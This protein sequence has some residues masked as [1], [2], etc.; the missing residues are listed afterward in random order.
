MNIPKLQIHTTNAKLG[1]NIHD[2][3][4][5]IEQ[6]PADLEIKQPP[7][8]ITIDVQKGELF[9][10]ASEARSYYGFKTVQELEKIAAQKGY[11]DSLEGIARRAREGYQ[12]M[13]IGK[14]RNAIQAI[15]KSKTNDIKKLGIAFIPKANT[16][17]IQYNPAT[18]DIDVKRN[19][20]I[21]NVKINKPIHKYTPGKVD[22]EMLQMPSVKIDWLL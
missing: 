1:L 6:P 16:V 3:Q 10:D 20:P 17:K 2:P 14:N 5:H 22:L 4:Q 21:I 12:L 18:V 7:A 15:A 11:Q 9:I 13:N 19:D 8:E